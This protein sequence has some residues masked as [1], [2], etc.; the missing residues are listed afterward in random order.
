[1]QKFILTVVAVCNLVVG[2]ETSSDIEDVWKELGIDYDFTSTSLELSDD[3][4]DS[5]ID[6]DDCDHCCHASA[7]L[8]AFSVSPIKLNRP[9]TD[10]VRGFS[11]EL[12]SRS[13]RAPP[14]PPPIV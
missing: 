14:I 3:P 7:H 5:G 6:G 10:A 4:N 11:V 13:G 12:H 2:L 8:V 1:M 9:T